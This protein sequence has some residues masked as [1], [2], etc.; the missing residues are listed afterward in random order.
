M[1]LKLDK[2]RKRFDKIVQES[3]ERAYWRVYRPPPGCVNTTELDIK[4]VCRMNK[5]STNRWMENLR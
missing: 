1:Q 5:Y 3:Q 4:K 2:D